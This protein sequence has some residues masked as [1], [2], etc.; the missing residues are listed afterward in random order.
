MGED[1]C[2]Q[3]NNKVIPVKKEGGGY[4]QKCVNPNCSVYYVL[5]KT[6]F[7]YDIDRFPVIGKNEIRK[8][9]TDAEVQVF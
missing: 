3:C 9:I 2:I 4:N 8:R 7:M 6:H 5:E 1:K